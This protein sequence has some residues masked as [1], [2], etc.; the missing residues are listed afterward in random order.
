MCRRIPNRGVSLTRPRIGQ[1]YTV[2]CSILNEYMEP[3]SFQKYAIMD[4]ARK[5]V[6]DG[7]ATTSKYQA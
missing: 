1:I 7:V 2:K 3:L 5:V 6:T 4:P